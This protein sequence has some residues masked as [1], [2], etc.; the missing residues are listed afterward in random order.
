ML[1]KVDYFTTLMQFLVAIKSTLSRILIS[2]RDTQK[3][4]ALNDNSSKL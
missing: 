4:G 2:K 3:Q 1:L